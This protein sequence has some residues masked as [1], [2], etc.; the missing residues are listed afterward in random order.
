MAAFVYMDS[1]LL[2]PFVLFVLTSV[3]SLFG[4]VL[5]DVLDGGALRSASKRTSENLKNNVALIIMHWLQ[6][7]ARLLVFPI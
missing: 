4:Y 1:G 6:L 7:G 5:F 3:V 2:S